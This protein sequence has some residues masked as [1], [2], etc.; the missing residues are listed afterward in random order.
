MG[1]TI[2]LHAVT[3]LELAAAL[4]LL[5]AIN[6]NFSPLDALLGLTTGEHQAL[7]LEEL[8]K[9]N[10]FCRRRGTAQKKR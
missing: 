9:A 8:I 3:R 7:P 5:K 4:G 2:Q 1:L 10:R 6:P